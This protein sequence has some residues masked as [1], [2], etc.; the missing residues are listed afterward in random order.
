MALRIDAFESQFVNSQHEIIVCKSASD[1][2]PS[3]EV[4][5]ERIYLNPS[6]THIAAFSHNDNLEFACA[7]ETGDLVVKEDINGV[8]NE[9][10][11]PSQLSTLGKIKGLA[12]IEDDV[13]ALSYESGAMVA[14]HV[15]TAGSGEFFAPKYGVT[16]RPYG[17]HFDANTY[18]FCAALNDG[19]IKTWSS[20]VCRSIKISK[21]METQE[22]IIFIKFLDEDLL[23]IG[24]KSDLFI[25]SIATII[26]ASKN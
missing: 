16:K 13:L 19:S 5:I 18:G 14:Y 20:D 17:C 6:S 25:S 23:A 1:E 8:V 3:S 10:V 22:Y 12:H 7:L 2:N 9:V 24:T 15:G 11:L 4:K 26:V 21:L